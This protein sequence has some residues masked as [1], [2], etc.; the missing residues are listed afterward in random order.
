MQHACAGTGPRESTARGG[1]AGTAGVQ[2]VEREDLERH[3]LPPR[4]LCEGVHEYRKA[5]LMCEGSRW[6]GFVAA[7]G[8]G[9]EV[10][11]AFA[12]AEAA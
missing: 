11:R 10:H 1:R 9:S 7:Q 5:P 2:R 8:G 12:M 3:A 4:A 6:A